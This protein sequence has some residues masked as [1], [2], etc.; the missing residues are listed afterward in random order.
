MRDRGENP[1]DGLAQG[2]R[3]LERCLRLVGP[4][5][6]L[7]QQ[8]L[9]LLPSQDAG[10]LAPCDKLLITREQLLRSVARMPVDRVGK[11][12]ATVAAIHADKDLALS[13]G[14]TRR[15]YLRTRGR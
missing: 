13:G 8:R 10:L 1:I 12:Q 15:V 4:L 11:I 9:G 14:W 3:L 7:M 5:S 2:N 6:S